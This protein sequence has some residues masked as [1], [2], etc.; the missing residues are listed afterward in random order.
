[1]NLKRDWELKIREKVYK[2]LDRLPIKD[3]RRVLEVIERLLLNPYAGDIEKMRGEENVWR[4]RVGAYR[5]FYE[6]RVQE[7]V[8]YVFRLDRRTSKTYRERKI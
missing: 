6:I 4:R 5:I 2:A 7:K 8:I 1:M 3:R